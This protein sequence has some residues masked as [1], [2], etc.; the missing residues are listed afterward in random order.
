MARRVEEG[1]WTGTY[2]QP[3]VFFPAHQTGQL[4][5]EHPAFRQISPKLTGV[6]QG[7]HPSTAARPLPKQNR[8]RED[9]EAA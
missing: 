6:P 2:W 8:I 3:V 7:E 1:R 9:G 4:H 5:F